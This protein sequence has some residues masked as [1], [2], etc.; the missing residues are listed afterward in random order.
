MSKVTGLRVRRSGV[1]IRSK[2]FLS[3][4]DNSDQLCHPPPKVPRLGMCG[5]IG[6]PLL[7]LYA[8]MAWTLPFTSPLHKQHGYHTKDAVERVL[9]LEMGLSFGSRFRFPMVS[10]E[11]FTD[12]IVSVAI[13][14]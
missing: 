4:I 11:F 2:R 6:L 8:L 12:I 13:W 1:R 10:L 14:P 3:S 5:A 7:L 9:N